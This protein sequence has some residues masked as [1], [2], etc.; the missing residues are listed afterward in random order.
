MGFLTDVALASGVWNESVLA[1]IYF[2]LVKKVK[3]LKTSTKKSR[4]K[5]IFL[6]TLTLMDRANGPKKD[7]GEKSNA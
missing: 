2:Y 5:L 4:N 7:D 6:Q 1:G 3:K